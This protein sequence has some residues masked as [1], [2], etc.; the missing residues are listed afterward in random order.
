MNNPERILLVQL[1]SNGDCLYATAVARQIKQ[2]HP[3]CHLTWAIAAYCRAILL[4]NPYIDETMVIPDVNHNNW[5]QHRKDFQRRLKQFKKEGRFDRIIRTQ[6]IDSNLAN[7][8]YCIRSAI[9]RGYGRPVTVP[10]QPVMRLTREE[11]EKTDRFAAEHALSGY[12]QVILVEFSP[13]SGQANFTA[14]MAIAMAERLTHD[15]AIAVVLSSNIKLEASRPSIIDGSALSLRETACLSKYCTL[16]VGCSSGT[17]WATTSDAGRRLPMVQILDP[18]AYW[19]NSVVN[20]HLRFGLPV[21]EIIEMTDSSEEKIDLCIRAILE[22]GFPSARVLY[23]TPL[24]IQFR[25]TRGILAYLLGKG[26]IAGAFRHI[27]INLRIFG[28]KPG[29]LRSIALGIATFPVVNLLN[30]RKERN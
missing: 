16:L 27:V 14:A 28:W 12:R 7:Y 2:D 29:L 1:F 8:D 30:K 20:D 24:P 21:D 15:P 22:K 17:T 5:K 11:L 18:N 9:F 4:N 3:G 19:L 13:R 10:V 23:H 6:I 26:D 25:M